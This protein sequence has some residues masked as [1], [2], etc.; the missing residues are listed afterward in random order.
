MKNRTTPDRTTSGL[1]G[2]TTG[3]RGYETS[4][5]IGKRIE[6]IFGWMKTV[7]IFRK[8]RYRGRGKV[9]SEV[10]FIEATF[11]LIG[12]ANLELAAT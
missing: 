9:Q 8:T 1:D 3:S 5:R 10:S 4:Q 7:G 6:E 11:D 12:M 2:R